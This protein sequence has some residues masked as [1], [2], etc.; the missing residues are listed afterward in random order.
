MSSFPGS[1]TDKSGPFSDRGLPGPL[2]WNEVRFGRKAN[3][4]D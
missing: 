2:F 4:Q 1:K 3:I